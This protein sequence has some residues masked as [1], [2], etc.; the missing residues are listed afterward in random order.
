MVRLV[1]VA[2]KALLGR[3][4]ASLTPESNAEL[5]GVR[6]VE[7][8][9]LSASLRLQAT[10]LEVFSAPMVPSVVIVPTIDPAEPKV[11]LTL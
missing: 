5:A 1:E 11:R 10:M 4:P 8:V 6:S 2:V 9:A 3:P 7:F